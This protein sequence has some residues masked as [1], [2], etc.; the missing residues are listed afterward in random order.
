LASAVIGVIGGFN[1]LF[2]VLTSPLPLSRPTLYPWTMP[3]IVTLVLFTALTLAIRAADPVFSGPQPGEKATP[4][5]TLTLHGPGSGSERDPLSL[6]QG[7]PTAIVFLHGIER[8]LVPLLRAIDTYG[9]SNASRLRT[10]IVFLQA[11]RIAG[12]QRV[13]AASGSLRL[14][15]PVSLSLDGIEG[16]GNY[17]LNKDCLMT[18]LGIRS[19]LV[20]TNFALIQPG[21]ADAPRVI[22]ALAQLCG[23]PHPPSA[24]T[25][26]ANAQPGRM[27]RMNP[28]RNPNTNSTNSAAARDPFPGAVPTDPILQGLLRRFI[29]PTNDDATVDAVLLEVKKH[30]GTNPDLRQQA[31]DGWTRVLHFGD[32]YG[33]AHS[34]KVGADFLQSLQKSP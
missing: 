23:D 14:Q 28:D 33:T 2:Q 15:A 31:I 17:G 10:E 27:D 25:L 21:I 12:E 30:I 32:R 19:N 1:S 29:R 7:A 13:K 18:I 16:P 11:D 8:S 9:A 4:F 6:H 5:K 20:V 34:R 3:R 26:L 22:A 24:E